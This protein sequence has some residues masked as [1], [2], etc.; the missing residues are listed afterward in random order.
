MPCAVM[1]CNQRRPERKWSCNWLQ[2]LKPNILQ[3]HPKILR[4]VF[5]SPKRRPMWASSDDPLDKPRDLKVVP[6]VSPWPQ[7]CV[8]LSKKASNWCVF[9]CSSLVTFSAW[10][11]NNMIAVFYAHR[12]FLTWWR[13]MPSNIREAFCPLEVATKI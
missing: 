9:D 13:I 2:L 1:A 7:V 11:E 8:V 6:E 4:L 10:D 3:Q 12:S 5:L